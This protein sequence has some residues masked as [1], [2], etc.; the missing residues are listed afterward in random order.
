MKEYDVTLIPGSV[1]PILQRRTIT[2]VTPAMKQHI[3][4]YATAVDKTC[5]KLFTFRAILEDIAKTV[6]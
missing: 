3:S 4:G 6:S 5:H 1:K 2:E